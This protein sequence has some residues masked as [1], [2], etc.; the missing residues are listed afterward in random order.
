MSRLSSK[1]RGM[2]SVFPCY[3][4]GLECD[5]SL[6][7]FWGFLKEKKKTARYLK[8]GKILQ[9]VN[10]NVTMWSNLATCMVFFFLILNLHSWLLLLNYVHTD[11]PISCITPAPTHSSAVLS[12]KACSVCWR[13]RQG[14]WFSTYES[15][16]WHKSCVNVMTPQLYVFII[17]LKG[18]YMKKCP[19]C[20]FL[21]CFR[22]F[23]K[24]QV[25]WDCL[26]LQLQARTTS[27]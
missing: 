16:S 2:C 1:C 18:F 9:N 14:K 17:K 3:W 11:W 25:H 21:F 13:D 22:T 23:G 20:L 7:N 24:R 12:R 15:K 5:F 8:N 10:Q 4:N 6:F 19:V 26:E 27:F